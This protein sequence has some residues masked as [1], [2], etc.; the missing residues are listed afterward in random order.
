MG[1]VPGTKVWVGNLGS[2]CEER[3]LRDEFSK[4]GELNK[5]IAF[6]FW[7]SA[8]RHKTP[9]FRQEGDSRDVDDL[10]HRQA[11]R[12][13]SAEEDLR[14]CGG[15]L[16]LTSVSV[17]DFSCQDGWL[18]LRLRGSFPP[19]ILSRNNPNYVGP[20][21]HASLGIVVCKG[22]VRVPQ[23]FVS[24][25]PPLVAPSPVS[26]IL[27][28]LVAISSAVFFL[29]F[30][31]FFDRYENKSQPTCVFTLLHKYVPFSAAAPTG[32]RNVLQYACYKG[33]L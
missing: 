4:F 27:A 3:D 18:I 17:F 1:D 20:P 22:S 19:P 5:V 28:P 11:C 30:L 6:C 26:S 12:T 13:E 25:L 24:A 23:L 32:C 14:A 7:S 31:G 33:D 8:T 2:T 21:Q 16:V 9:A 10:G 15:I 29:F